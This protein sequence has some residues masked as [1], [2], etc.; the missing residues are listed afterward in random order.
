MLLTIPQAAD[1]CERNGNTAS[2]N[3]N[4]PASEFALDLICTIE[5][6]GQN[7]PATA[8]CQIEDLP[9]EFLTISCTDNADG[10][11]DCSLTSRADSIGSTL[12]DLGQLSPPQI[13]IGTDILTAC[14]L[15][16]GTQAF[17]NDCTAILAA[18]ADDDGQAVKNSLDAITP[19]DA[20]QA[21]DNS[22]FMLQMPVDQIH[23]RLSRLRHGA[24]PVDVS[25]LRL[26][27]GRQWVKAG[28]QL[29]ANHDTQIDSLADDQMNPLGRLGVFI[30][31][32]LLDS[33]Q[34][35]GKNE[36]TV[37]S[38]TNMLTAGID[39]RFSD[40][41]ITGMA[42]SAAYSETDYGEDRGSLDTTSYLLLLYT[43]YIKG[44][45]HIDAAAGFGGDSHE[46]TRRLICTSGCTHSFEQTAESDFNGDQII[47]S[48]QAGY[49]WLVN[50]FSITP[51][52]GLTSLQLAVDG[53]REVMSEPDAPGAGF[54]L[55][56]EKQDQDLLTATL[57]TQVRY[58]SSQDWGVFLPYLDMQMLSELETDPTVVSGSFI[59]NVATD[60]NFELVGNEI[61]DNYFKIGLG[62]SFQFKNGNA[63]FIDLKTTLGHDEIDATQ[64]SLGWR[65]EME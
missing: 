56:M 32:M 45:F 2:C 38:G 41:F 18:V 54:A 8:D 28:E 46:Q 61:D 10:T 34:E 49:E 42:Y 23:R 31:G 15:Q 19:L 25:S 52:I 5:D 40:E 1:G 6:P 44:N 17:Q 3:L 24:A 59:G 50:N 4:D 39:Y 63:A 58:A 35:A 60:S 12:D 30:D 36:G 16:G 37:D 11:G 33:D 57:G 20:D 26:Y 43:S 7:Q 9:P 62:S 55:Q 22:R 47:A 29:A 48:L 14:V 13:E 65:W 64:I 53:Y 21:L 51:Y 27:D